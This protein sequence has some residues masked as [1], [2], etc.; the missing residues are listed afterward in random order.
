ML[1]W[2]CQRAPASPLA[3]CRAALST[4]LLYMTPP[5][6][7][8]SSDCKTT[9]YFGFLFLRMAGPS[10]FFF[11]KKERFYLFKIFYWFLVGGGERNNDVSGKH[12]SAAPLRAPPPS[13]IKPAT[14]ACMCP[15]RESNRQPFSA[16]DEAQ[17]TE[18]HWPG[19]A[20][21]FIQNV[22]ACQES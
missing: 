4:T 1:W 19:Q 14:R 16:R 21:F 15:G 9:S 8:P 12:R 7:S 18:P 13:G 5:P 3:G 20:F 6:R 2:L 17:P 11:L 10:F 22:G